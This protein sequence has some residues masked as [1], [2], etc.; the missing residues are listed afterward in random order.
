MAGQFCD[1]RISAG[2]S[3]DRDGAAGSTG[4]IQRS[5]GAADAAGPV[6][7]WRATA[8]PNGDSSHVPANTQIDLQRYQNDLAAITPGHE[9][10]LFSPGIIS[11]NF[12]NGYIA[13]YTAG[14]DQ[15]LGSAKLSVGYVWTAG[16]KLASVF[17]PNGYTGASA[18]F[19]PFTQYDAAGH[20]AG[21]FGPESL[22]NNG[23]HSIYHA[24]QTSVTQTHSKIGLSFQASYTFSKSIDD[25]SAVLG[26]PSA[27]TGTILQ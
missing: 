27:N 12:R 13:T 20:V 24:L 14:I 11:R 22:M 15:D 17:F 10:Q 1:R 5:G 7:G 2:V 4:A 18:A 8:V 6:H 21:G 19:A 16:V 23:A 3:A 25:T 26:L 9:V